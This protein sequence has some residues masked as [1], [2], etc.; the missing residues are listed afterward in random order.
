MLGKELLDDQMLK[1]Y[2]FAQDSL[3]LLLGRKYFPS[4]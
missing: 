2:P 3:I 1:P 4:P